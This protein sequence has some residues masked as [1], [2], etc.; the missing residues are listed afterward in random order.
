MV[1]IHNVSIFFIFV[2]IIKS[3]VLYTLIKCPCVLISASVWYNRRWANLAEYNDANHTNNSTA[4]D[5]LK[6]TD[7]SSGKSMVLTSIFRLPSK[8]LK[9]LV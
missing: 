7:E 6:I 3:V 4:R 1:N 2:Y 9:V 8:A 5:V